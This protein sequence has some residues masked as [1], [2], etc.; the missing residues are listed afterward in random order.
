MATGPSPAPK[1]RLA[2]LHER[3]RR[4]LVILGPAGR[5]L[6]FRFAIEQLGERAVLGGVE[7][8]LHAAKRDAR[9]PREFLRERKSGGAKLRVGRDAVDDAERERLRGVER[10]GGE[11]E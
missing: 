10:L 3:P 4:F 7:I 1:H 6:A 8:L 9:A 11:I 5:D 2:L